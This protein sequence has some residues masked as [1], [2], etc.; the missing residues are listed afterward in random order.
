M[1]MDRP[2]A[3][4]VVSESVLVRLQEVVQ[5]YDVRVILTYGATTTL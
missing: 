4:C 1:R 3:V 2:I 5:T